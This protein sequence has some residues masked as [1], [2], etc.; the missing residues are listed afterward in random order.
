[1]SQ[2]RLL[3]RDVQ[4]YANDRRVMLH[5]DSIA[6]PLVMGTVREADGAP[7][8]FDMGA[9]TAADGATF[10][11]RPLRLGQV[12]IDFLRSARTLS[13]SFWFETPLGEVVL[14][15]VSRVNGNVIEGEVASGK[16]RVVTVDLARV[17]KLEVMELDV[18]RSIGKTVAIRALVT[19]AVVGVAAIIV[20]LTKSSCPFAARYGCPVLPSGVVLMTGAALFAGVGSSQFTIALKIM[21]NS[22]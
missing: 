13:G 5:G 15:N 11:N 18:G 21:L 17:T 2:E 6:F 19:G 20:A 14:L 22:P 12:S 16:G 10:T 9:A 1:M 4:F 7:V 3:A 8:R